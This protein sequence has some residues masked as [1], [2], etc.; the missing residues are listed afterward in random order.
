MHNDDERDYA[1]EQYSANILAD[2][3]DPDI[4]E[5]VPTGYVV[6]LRWTDEHAE[7]LGRRYDSARS[8]MI[9]WDRD[10]ALAHLAQLREVILPEVATLEMREYAP[11]PAGFGVD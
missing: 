6:L 9:F 4:D 2:E 5:T 8:T 7:Y 11:I 10:T 1:E 3:N